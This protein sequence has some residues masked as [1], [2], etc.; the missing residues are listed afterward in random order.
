MQC[1][2]EV[3]LASIFVTKVRFAIHR[4]AADAITVGR[5]A[6]RRHNGDAKCRLFFQ[7]YAIYLFIHLFLH[8]R[9][10]VVYMY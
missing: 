5:S 4:A 9:P 2:F 6:M 8:K 3:P 7:C 1:C 10:V